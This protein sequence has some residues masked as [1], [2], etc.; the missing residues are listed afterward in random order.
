MKKAIQ[1]KRAWLKGET[2]VYSLQ[3]GLIKPSDT[4]K[5]EGINKISTESSE[6]IAELIKTQKEVEEKISIQGPS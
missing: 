4:Q 1:I 6:A 2:I 5:K 3:K